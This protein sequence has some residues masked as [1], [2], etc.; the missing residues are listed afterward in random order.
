MDDT[1]N[2]AWPIEMYFLLALIFVFI[3]ILVKAP[4]ALQKLINKIESDISGND[5]I[6]NFEFTFYWGF[7]LFEKQTTISINSNKI[8]L[9][10]NLKKCFYFNLKWSLLSRAIFFIIP[11]SKANMSKIMK[12]NP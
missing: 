12:E 11:L 8:E 6:V 2:Q 7:F 9:K 4:K 1:Y 5:E 10:E 3:Y